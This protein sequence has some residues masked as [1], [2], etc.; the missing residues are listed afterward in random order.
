MDDK[1][2]FG[3]LSRTTKGSGVQGLGGCWRMTRGGAGGAK[4]LGS[5]SF[6]Q[7]QISDSNF[8]PYKKKAN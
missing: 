6:N 8:K 7:M 3:G 4:V 1:V 2:T 5:F